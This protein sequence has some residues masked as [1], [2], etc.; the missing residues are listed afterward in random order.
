MESI[1]GIWYEE[2]RDRWRVKL[3]CDGV[4]FHRSYHRNYNS[5]YN[6]WQTAKQK[7]VRPRPKL[8]IPESSDINRF[9][10]QPLIGGADR[11]YPASLGR[12]LRS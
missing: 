8:S 12:R 5:A 10:C 3:F 6:A 11:F 7:M 9:L 2:K 4:L 1:P